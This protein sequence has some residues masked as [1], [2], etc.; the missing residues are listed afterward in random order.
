[1]PP[2]TSQRC[3]PPLVRRRVACR[4][5]TMCRLCADSDRRPPAVRALLSRTPRR[6]C[7]CGPEGMAAVGVVSAMLRSRFDLRTAVP[8]VGSSA[9][10]VR[11][12]CLSI[13]PSP[14]R[15]L[16]V[17]R[18][19]PD[20]ATI[21]ALDGEHTAVHDLWPIPAKRARLQYRYNIIH[22]FL[23]GRG[24]PP[25]VS[26]LPT[27]SQKQRQP[28]GRMITPKTLVLYSSASTRPSAMNCLLCRL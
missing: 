18:R 25:S 5:L 19:R 27:S 22:Y 3:S 17:G 20:R 16:D 12:I 15:A 14:R 6:K 24:R 13:V 21:R 23:A 11:G 28:M 8:R 10:I 7:S 1:M 26:R 2:A 9:E 4:F